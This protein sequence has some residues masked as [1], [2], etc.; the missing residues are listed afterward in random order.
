MNDFAI[1]II[2]LIIS[3]VLLPA[4]P[5]MIIT[6]YVTNRNSGHIATLF[7]RVDEIKAGIHDVE[8]EQKLVFQKFEMAVNRLDEI[9][10][11]LKQ[12]QKDKHDK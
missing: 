2:L 9:I 4:I 6:V 7:Q 8:T 11:E 12:Q 10:T 3:G 1:S 5:T